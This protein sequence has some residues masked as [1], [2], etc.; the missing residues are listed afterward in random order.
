VE[1]FR[2]IKRR[3][4][5]LKQKKEVIR[6]KETRRFYFAYYFRTWGLHFKTTFPLKTFPPYVLR[7]R[8]AL[9]PHNLVF[10]MSFSATNLHELLCGKSNKFPLKTFT[11]RVV[12]HREAHE[13]H[14]LC[15]VRDFLSTIHSSIDEFLCGK[16]P[17]ISTTDR[18]ATC[19]LIQGGTWAA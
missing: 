17:Y 18:T 8:E 1:R 13:P 15:F 19:S 16:E 9:E 6:G 14:C 7:Y 12:R 11:P 5:S 10:C 4:S 2:L 3:P